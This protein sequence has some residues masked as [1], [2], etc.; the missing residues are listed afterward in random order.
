MTVKPPSYRV[1]DALTTYFQA[2]LDSPEFSSLVF[3]S[4]EAQA[5][6]AQT[7]EFIRGCLTSSGDMVD[8][9]PPSHT[10]ITSFK[11]IGIAIKKSCT[12]CEQPKNTSFRLWLTHAICQH[13]FRRS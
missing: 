9:N 7:V 6:R 4:H 12:S 8:S 5:F 11:D 3:D 10:I 13:K 2:E 1:G